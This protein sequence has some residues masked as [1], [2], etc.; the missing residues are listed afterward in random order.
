MN[1]IQN[2]VLHNIQIFTN[3]S[4]EEINHASIFDAVT[5]TLD[6]KINQSDFISFFNWKCGVLGTPFEK[7]FI[8]KLY[9]EYSWLYDYLYL[10]R[11]KLK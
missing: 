2:K 8:D 1:D 6:T 3:T 5:E 11:A 10:N 7:V 4:T 9:K